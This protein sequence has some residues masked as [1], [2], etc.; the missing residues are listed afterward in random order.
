MG[1][2]GFAEI[3]LIIGVGFL[4]LGPDQLPKAM[5]KLGRLLGEA[6]KIK[7]EFQDNIDYVQQTVDE[8]VEISEEPKRHNRTYM[9]KDRMISQKTKQRKRR[10]KYV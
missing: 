4:I 7:R 6:E 8:T 9:K 10:K 1:S 5:R 2:F 3:L